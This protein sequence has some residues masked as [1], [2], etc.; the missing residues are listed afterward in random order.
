M[1]ISRTVQLRNCVGICKE[2]EDGSLHEFRFNVPANVKESRLLK[3]CKEHFEKIYD[4]ATP[5]EL[6][7]VFF[8]DEEIVEMKLT[9]DFFDFLAVATIENVEE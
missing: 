1:K 3:Y 5:A 4:P 2:T 7:T 6:K 8:A 9:V